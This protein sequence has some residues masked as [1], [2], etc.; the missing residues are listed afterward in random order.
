M[1]TLSWSVVSVFQL[2]V[3]SRIS[4][5]MVPQQRYSLVLKHAG[6]VCGSNNM[7]RTGIP[8]SRL[9]RQ[10]CTEPS[11]HSDSALP[12]SSRC[13]GSGKTGGFNKSDVQGLARVFPI[14]SAF[15][16]HG[17]RLQTGTMTDMAIAKEQQV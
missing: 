17:V 3:R 6:R 10:S 9:L 13:L 2:S 14:P 8:V 12:R 15:C 11:L 4:I 1:Q 7:I 16:V 5:H